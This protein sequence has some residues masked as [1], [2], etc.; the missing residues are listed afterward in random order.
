MSGIAPQRIAVLLGGPSAEHDVSL[1]SGRAIAGD[2][3]STR[4]NS[5]H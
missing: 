2:R 3:K 1:V 4:L 5:S